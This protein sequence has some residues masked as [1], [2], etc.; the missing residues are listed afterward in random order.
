MAVSTGK[1]DKNQRKIGK[2]ETYEK[3]MELYGTNRWVVLQQTMF[4]V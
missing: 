3:I 4:D 2:S 1:C